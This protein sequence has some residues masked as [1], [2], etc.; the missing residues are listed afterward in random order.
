MTVLP[1]QQQANIGLL[2][3]SEEVMAYRDTVQKYAEQDGI[4]DYV[5]YLLAIMMTEVCKAE[6]RRQEFTIQKCCITKLWL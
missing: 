4:G 1:A 3:V 2:N 5:D 6:I